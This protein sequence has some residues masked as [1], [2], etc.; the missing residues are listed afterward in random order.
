MLTQHVPLVN[1]D[2]TQAERRD[3]SSDNALLSATLW[4]MGFEHEFSAPCV[5]RLSAFIRHHGVAGLLDQA[6]ADA[7][8][9]GYSA[10]LMLERRAIA[11]RAL[12]LGATL[13]RLTLALAACGLQ[14]L[15]LKGPALALQAH[16]QLCARGGVDL[17]ILLGEDQWPE[18]LR[19][20]NEQGY[21]VA[22]GQQLP[23]PKAHH[24]LV[25]THA[26]GLPR[27]ELHR[28]LLRN[29]Y[30]LPA[31]ICM[32][33][34]VDLQGVSLST[35]APIHAL[36]YL[37]A[38]ASQHSFRKLVWL[39][40]IHALLQ[41]ADLDAEQLA[42][43]IRRTG[44]RAMLDACL[45]L[46]SVLFGAQ[47]AAPLQHVRRPCRAS[48]AMVQAALDGLREA[49]TDDQVA[50]RQGIF[51]RMLI[52]I[53]MQD[54]VLAKW[55]ALKGWLSPTTKDS[56]WVILPQKLSFLYPIIRLARLV[57]RQFKK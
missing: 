34:Q 2:A 47:V 1:H 41:R 30:L 38:H 52:D 56:G 55:H 4:L 50:T 57:T 19:V 11:L 44:T 27:V 8:G 24:E 39:L 54:N 12:S 26:G 23:L 7:L 10:P 16:G 32:T 45:T 21:S 20:F 28:R 48:R 37:I 42:A 5:V 22:A 46:L 29:Q 25:L 49:L 17:D 33:Q 15:A 6:R 35:L 43:E 36:P 31:E 14:P 3:S 18:A 9:I 53:A 51:K 40:D 13:R